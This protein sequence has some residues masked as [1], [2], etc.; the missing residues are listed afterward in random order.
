MND[1][2]IDEELLV[3]PLTNRRAGDGHRRPSRI[4]EQTL[5]SLTK[6]HYPSHRLR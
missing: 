6:S 1:T 5:E 2:E 4:D 3:A